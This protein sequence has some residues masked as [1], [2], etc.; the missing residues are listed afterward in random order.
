MSPAQRTSP[1]LTSRG[2]CRVP[3]SPAPGQKRRRA[4]TEHLLR[5]ELCPEP[6]AW[7][8]CPTCERQ[9]PTRQV[10]TGVSAA[11]G[12]NQGDPLC[13]RQQRTEPGGRGRKEAALH[14]AGQPGGRWA[15]GERA[16]QGTGGRVGVPQ[17]SCSHRPGPGSKQRGACTR[18]RPPAPP[19]P[20]GRARGAVWLTLHPGLPPLRSWDRRPSCASAP[21]LSLRIRNLGT[22]LFFCS[23]EESVE[24]RPLP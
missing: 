3:S 18:T 12:T 4:F 15:G 10:P 24:A 2:T 17:H 22:P 11:G 9:H 19:A 13:R 6:A 16:G 23:L 1:S 8:S 7:S 5:A 20:K 14:H 21:W